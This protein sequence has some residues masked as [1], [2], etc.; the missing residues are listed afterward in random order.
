MRRFLRYH[1]DFSRNYL[2]YCFRGCRIQIPK[3]KPLECS[4][5]QQQFIEQIHKQVQNRPQI[6]TKELKRRLQR[7]MLR[8]ELQNLPKGCS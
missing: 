1:I 3:S 4:V 2:G 7:P 6:F 5:F 8:V